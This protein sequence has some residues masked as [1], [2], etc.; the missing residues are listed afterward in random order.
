M[1]NGARQSGRWNSYL[2]ESQVNQARVSVVRGNWTHGVEQ[3]VYRL[4]DHDKRLDKG[5]EDLD[6]T[7][8]RLQVI[9]HTTL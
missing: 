8:F 3:M 6:G 2:K 5:Q 9:V 7:H 1:K 4:Q